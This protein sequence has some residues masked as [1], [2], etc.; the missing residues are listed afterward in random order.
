MKKC[1]CLSA[2][3]Y[4]R[5]DCPLF[6]V[7]GKEKKAPPAFKPLKIDPEMEARLEEFE[8]MLEDNSPLYPATTH[9][10][11]RARKINDAANN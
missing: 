9:L 4:H 2:P 3:D 10:V 7:Y 11:I 6:D 1:K 8:R 5:D